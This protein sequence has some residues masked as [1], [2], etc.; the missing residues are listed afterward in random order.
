M[1]AI[2]HNEIPMQSSWYEIASKCHYFGE[3]VTNSRF[4]FQDVTMN[5]DVTVTF[6]AANMKKMFVGRVTARAETVNYFIVLQNIR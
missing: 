2:F 1:L 6:C 4:R 3:N 5:L